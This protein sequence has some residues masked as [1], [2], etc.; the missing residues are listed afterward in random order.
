M[1]NGPIKEIQKG[2]ILGTTPC[3][4]CR[5]PVQVKVNSGAHAYAYC[6]ATSGGCGHSIQC[7]GDEATIALVSSITA[8]KP[9][10]QA[11]LAHL[12]DDGPADPPAD[13]APAPA[14]E[15]EP[16]PA[17]PHEPPQDPDG[18]PENAV[19]ESWYER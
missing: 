15:P 17:P 2:V 4:G 11:E 1:P 12:V 14:P 7:R 3:P 9:G 19:P 16:D 10:R 5:K 13:P 18:D 6:N 8:W